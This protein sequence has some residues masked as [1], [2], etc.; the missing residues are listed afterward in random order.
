MKKQWIILSALLVLLI[1]GIVL[2]Q[3]KGDMLSSGD[4]A[5][6]YFASGRFSMGVFS[7]GMFSAGIFSIGIFSIGIFSVSVF[8][9]AL[10]GLGFFIAARHKRL[11]KFEVLENED[12]NI[13]A[14]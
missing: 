14:Q 7:S 9:V 2:H 10:Y 3:T 4:Y 11:P 8:N 12:K 6:N 1:L 13:V 5:F